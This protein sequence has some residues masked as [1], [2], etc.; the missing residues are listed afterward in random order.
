MPKNYTLQTHLI[1]RGSS[2]P[3]GME[4]RYKLTKFEPHTGLER[5]KN[6]WFC[7]RYVRKFPYILQIELLKGYT[8]NIQ[9]EIWTVGTLK[10]TREITTQNFNSIG[11]DLKS[12]EYLD[13]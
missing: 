12:L 2:I 6:P 13:V 9:L 11:V 4:V 7:E 3:L 5:G 1:Y 10:S 8:K